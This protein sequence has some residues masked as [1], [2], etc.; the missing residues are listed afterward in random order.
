[1]GSHHGVIDIRMYVI[2]TCWEEK[3]KI[4]RSFG[5]GVYVSVLTT[6]NIQ[7]AI[8][9]IECR[10]IRLTPILQGK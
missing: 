2:I 6:T 3:R 8:S 7:S 5:D 4:V 1:M 9:Y 10:S